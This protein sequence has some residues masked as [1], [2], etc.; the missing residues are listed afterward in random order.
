M[1][2]LIVLGLV[3]SLSL[4]VAGCSSGGGGAAPSNSTTTK[5]AGVSYQVIPMEANEKAAEAIMPKVVDDYVARKKKDG[6]VE[7][8]DYLDV[9]GV[10]P[11]FIGYNVNAFVPG[12]KAEDVKIIEVSYVNGLI[13]LASI[14]G[15]PLSKENAEPEELYK[16]N[17]VAGP[18]SPGSSEKK[19]LAAAKAWVDKNYPGTDWTYGIKQYIFLYR[20]GDVGV[21]VGTT[22]DGGLSRSSGIIQLAK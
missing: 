4:V 9:T 20:K 10:T 13:T 1:R 15:A 8:K 11:E 21:Y 16:T 19:A 5:P 18:A 14:P 22:L 3:L 17:A 2:K 6:K 7:G 12:A